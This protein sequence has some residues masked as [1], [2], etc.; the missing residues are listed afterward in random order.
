MVRSRTGKTTCLALWRSALVK[1]SATAVVPVVEDDLLFVLV[2]VRRKPV[3]AALCGL[4]NTPL[5][6]HATS[7]GGEAELPKGDVLVSAQALVKAV[8]RMAS[9]GSGPSGY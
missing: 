8:A 6:D 5:D 2:S 7:R 9:D 3:V 1:P 4:R